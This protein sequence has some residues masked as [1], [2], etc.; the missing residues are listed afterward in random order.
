M[1]TSHSFLLQ[2]GRWIAT[3]RF[4][5]AGG[6]HPARG[7][8]TVLRDSALWRIKGV[9]EVLADPPM[10]ME[11]RYGIRPCNAPDRLDWVSENPA[12]GRLTGTFLLLDDAILSEF[13]SADGAWRGEERLARRSA[14]RYAAAGRLLAGKY[15]VSEWRVDL[16][17]LGSHA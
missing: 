14:G 12:I 4:C 17:R 6:S 2:P 7:E 15:V 8:T 1:S 5:G 9:M 13:R 3:G 10:R 16:V 11:N